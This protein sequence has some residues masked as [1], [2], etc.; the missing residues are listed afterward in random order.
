MLKRIIEHEVTVFPVV[1]T[2][3]ATLLSL[4][5]EWRL[6]IS[7]A[8]ARV[9]NTAAALPAEFVPRARDGVPERAHLRDVRTHRVQARR[10]PRA[11]ARAR[12]A[13]VGRQA[14]FL[15]RRSFCCHP[16]AS[17]CRPARPGILHVRGPH[18]MVGYWKQPELTDHML[19]PGR[20][21]GER[22]LCT[23]DYL[24]G[25]TRTASCTSSAA[26]D[27]II[28]TRGEKVSPIEVENALH[29]D[30]RRA[31]GGRRRRA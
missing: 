3:G 19:K 2:I 21:P 25:W 6:D 12:E 10:I 7:D 22:V 29:R 30:R 14:R 18:V 23:H 11:G 28:K 27:D 13:D 24:H 31:R 17:R 5:R 16:T 1:P 15:A 8:C 4:N 9:T 26:R 20:L